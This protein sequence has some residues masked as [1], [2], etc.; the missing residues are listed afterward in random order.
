[1]T[2]WRRRPHLRV[3]DGTGGSNSGPQL[4]RAPTLNTVLPFRPRVAAISDKAHRSEGE[5]SSDRYP[6]GD[7]A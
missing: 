6:G 5:P 1:M 7:A 2:A 4:E 3:I